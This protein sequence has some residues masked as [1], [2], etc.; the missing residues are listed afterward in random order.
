M[1]NTQLSGFIHTGMIGLLRPK[2]N[3]LIIAIAKYNN[4]GI[5][6]FLQIILTY[7]VMCG[8]AWTAM[9]KLILIKYSST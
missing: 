3:L 1:Y 7:I 6:N 2:F 5:I 4:N 9:Q 8:M